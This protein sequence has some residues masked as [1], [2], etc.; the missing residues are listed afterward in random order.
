M[1]ENC[2]WKYILKLEKFIKNMKLIH[3]KNVLVSL[4][5]DG[6]FDLTNN[7]LK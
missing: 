5:S 6:D 4:S 7:I 2:E 1:N 3:T